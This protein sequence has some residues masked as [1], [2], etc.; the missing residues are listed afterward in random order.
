MLKIEMRIRTGFM[1]K[2]RFVSIVI[3]ICLWPRK[4]RAFSFC[5]LK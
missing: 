2:V 5:S 3:N 4:G 1:E